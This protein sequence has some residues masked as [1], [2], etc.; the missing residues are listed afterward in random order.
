MKLYCKVLL[1]L[2]FLPLSLSAQRFPF[3]NISLDQG[4]PQ[5]VVYKIV[6]DSKG[7]IWFATQDGVGKY[8]GSDFQN[9]SLEEGLVDNMCRT[10]IEAPD[11]TIWVA[12]DNGISIIDSKK[13]YS[14]TNLY[15][16]KGIGVRALYV[17]KNNNILVGSTNNGVYIV[18]DTTITKRYTT[19]NGLINDRVYSIISNSSGAIFVGT[20]NGLSV[21]QNDEIQNY[22]T[23]N[24]LVSNRIRSIEI[25]EKNTVWIGGYGNGITY[26]KNN[27]FKKLTEKDG[28]P[29]NKINQILSLGDGELLIAT[30]GDG[31]VKLD[32]NFAITTI[33]QKNGLSNSSVQSLAKDNENDLW[34]G[35]WGSGAFLLKQKHILHFDISDGLPESNITSVVVDYKNRI[36]VST[37]NEGIVRFDGH[38]PVYFNKNN[39]ILPV[40]RVYSLVK[41]SLNTI[42]IGTDLDLFNYKDEK[43]NAIHISPNHPISIRKIAVNTDGSVWAGVFGKGVFRYKDGETMWFSRKDG[44]LNDS[45]FAIAHRKNGETWI[46]S[47]GGISIIKNL[48]VIKNISN[49]EGLVDNRISALMEDSKQTMWIGTYKS[50]LVHMVNDSSTIYSIKN[51]LTNNLITFILEDEFGSIWVGTKKGVNRFKDRKISQYGTQN[52]LISNETNPNSAFYSS[53]NLFIGTV[54]GLTVFDLSKEETNKNP[55]PVYITKTTV[56]DREIEL[57]KHLNFKY[58]DNYIA[59]DYTVVTF[60][61]HKQINYKVRLIG[62]DDEWRETDKKTIQYTNLPPGE[63]TF[64][65]V[66]FTNSYI[67]S[68]E[69]ARISFTIIPPIWGTKWFRFVAILFILFVIYVVF[70]LKARQLEKQNNALE[71]IVKSRT[72]ELKK[73]EEL[74]R[75]ISENAGDLI[76]VCKISGETIYSSPSFKVL[77]G[78]TSDEIQGKNINL[79]TKESAE[80]SLLDVIQSIKQQKTLIK[81][82]EIELRHKLG[83]WLTFIIT[84][85]SFESNTDVSAK[86]E[87]QFVLVGHDISSRKLTEDELLRSKLEAESANIAKS[88]F[89]ASMSH[90]LRTPLNAI[91]GFAQ[92][93]SNANDIPQKHREYVNIM[94]NSGEHLLSMINDILDLSKIEAGRMDLSKSISSLHDFLYDL[95][96][97]MQMQARKNNLSLQF[98]K[99]K[100]VPDLLES[101]FNKLRQVLI[102]LIGNAI[103]YTEKGT[104]WVKTYI[105]DESMLVFEV[106]DTGP[107]IPPEQLSQIFDAF[108]QVQ[109]NNFSKGT[110]L[111]LTISMKLAQL[112]NGEITVSSKVG[113]GS[114]F[115]L[116]IPFEKIEND[117]MLVPSDKRMVVK[118]IKE[119]ITP[120]KIVIIDDV[121]ENRIILK[122]FLDQVGCICFDFELATH[123]IQK[124]EEIMPDIVLTDIIMPEMNGKEFLTAFRKLPIVAEVPVVA[125]T[126]S[127]FAESRTDLIQF[128]FDEFL[129]KPVDMDHL[130]SIISTFTFVEFDKVERNEST[131]V[132]QDLDLLH[133][134]IHSLDAETKTLLAETLELLDEADIYNLI[135]KLENTPLLKQQLTD[136]I[137]EKN[138]RFIL[139]L[140]EQ[141]NPF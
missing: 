63:Y 78:Y 133:Q 113:E 55:P 24:G 50:G 26:F 33:S 136:A 76:A 89:L 65:V 112:L 27:T 59:F 126:A 11:G 68:S 110:G 96:N 82:I 140:S 8:N 43:L 134:E 20:N 119:G 114:I 116:I 61:N 49:Q 73:S 93:M 95:E 7:F 62:F 97:M 84:V 13:N 105:S 79:L 42:W 28:F 58:F 70:R 81:T 48:K 115:K 41:D 12:T 39:S 14:I 31:V 130:L 86:D 40:D 87:I 128:G 101:D 120:P 127:I 109:K 38:K 67:Y 108:H 22:T 118:G 51:G 138:Y 17:D 103:K 64:E 29:K 141:L 98:E 9:F 90:E 69:P 132:Q 25:D 125:I 85:S 75:L 111:G 66:A 56:W 37:N 15:S 18:T 99:D 124:V 135:N 137:K 91:L 30:D 107:G 2:G 6:Q 46:G 131:T 10:I 35:T 32:S 106:K 21:I 45:V 1:F 117:P 54:E 4:L 121:D 3:E 36:W 129:H 5:S 16:F 77:L 72:V 92:I 88:R 52:G 23:Q 47:D 34:I 53:P 139:S 102:N 19:E 83:H 104:I 80:N 44:M 94:H 60:N 71:L 100:D 74:F 123:A 57:N 122:D